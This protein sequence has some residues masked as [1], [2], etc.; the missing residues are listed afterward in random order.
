MTIDFFEFIQIYNEMKKINDVYL[1]DKIM[2][3]SFF[4]Q[5]TQYNRE[6]INFS[7]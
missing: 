3:F 7:F 2:I 4:S 6:S 1:K 5:K